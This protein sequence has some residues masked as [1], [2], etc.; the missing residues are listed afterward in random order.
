MMATAQHGDRRL[1]LGLAFVVIVLALLVGVFYKSAILA[2]LRPGETIQVE[3]ARAYKLDPAESAVKIA[4]SGVG[5]VESVEHTRTDTSLVTLKV[6]RGTRALLGKAPTALIRP[7]TILGGRYYVDLRPGGVP[8]T[9]TDERIPLDR[10]TTP[11]ELNEALVALQP[12]AIQGLQN[13][14]TDVDLTLRGGGSDAL[15]TLATA[16]PEPLSSLGPVL[17]SVRGEQPDVDLARLVADSDRA[18]KVLLVQNGQ[19]SDV[20][21]SFDT[22]TQAL[23]RQSTPLA[24]GIDN[25]PGAL[26]AIDDAARHV[27][28]TLDELRDTAPHAEATAKA[29]DPLMARLDPVLGDLRPVTEKL[30]DLMRDARPLVHELIPVSHLGRNVFD[31]LRGPVLDRVNGPVTDALFT[32]WKGTGRFAGS[33]NNGNAFY[34]EIASMFSNLDNSTVQH[35]QNGSA[36]NFEVGENSSIL[37]GLPFGLDDRTERLNSFGGPPR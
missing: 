12:R 23:A 30:P 26:V 21:D 14:L 6:D 24:Q 20:V 37:D 5:V 4:G 36:I 22:T 1:W 11:V 35:D 17:A 3:F 31:D 32:R 27:S 19:L 9:F 25:L 18:A 34:Q 7:T 13:T 29:F 8:G 28:V 10:A 2:A 16:A 33:G 15:R